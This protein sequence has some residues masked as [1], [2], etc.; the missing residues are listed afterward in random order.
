EKNLKG[1]IRFKHQGRF[2]QIPRRK[3]VSEADEECATKESGKDNGSAEMTS[4]TQFIVERND[5]AKCRVIETPLPSVMQLPENGLL[6]K[7]ERFAL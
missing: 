7:V 1:K 6:V 2:K 3:N 4:S 5:L